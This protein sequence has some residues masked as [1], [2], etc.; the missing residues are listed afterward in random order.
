MQASPSQAWVN[1]ATGAA[2]WP[3][4][5]GASGV[6]TTENATLRLTAALVVAARPPAWPGATGAPESAST[7]LIL[8]LPVPA[9]WVRETAAAG[10]VQ[11]SGSTDDFSLQ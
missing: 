7:P 4:P 6:S 9:A 5:V 8:P 10:S 1:A 3:P 11:V 2:F